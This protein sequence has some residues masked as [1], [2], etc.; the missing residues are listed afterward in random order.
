MTD[1]KQKHYHDVDSETKSREER[2]KVYGDFYRRRATRHEWEKR[3]H[4][5]PSTLINVFFLL[6]TALISSMLPVFGLA[7]WLIYR[8][9][10]EGHGQY[11]F[12]GFALGSA[13]WVMATFTTLL[14]QWFHYG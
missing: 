13:Y 2:K 4:P 9:V 11:A 8:D 6:F 10:R 7:A 14:M 3:M 12:V 5:V 1:D